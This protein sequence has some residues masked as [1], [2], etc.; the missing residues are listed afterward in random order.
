MSKI[1]IRP[2]LVAF[3]SGALV[4]IFEILG[5]R[6]VWPYIGTSLFVWTS[7]IALILWAL[8]VGHYVWGVLSDKRASYED[9]S[10]IFLTSAATILLLLT[11]KDVVLFFVSANISD[12]RVSAIILALLLFSPTSFLLGMLS[13]IV[14]KIR[15]TR[16]ETG[17][18]VVGRIGS[19]ATIGSIVGTLGAWFFL[20]PFFGV[21]LLLLALATT[22]VLL[23]LWVYNHWHRKYQIV[24]LWIIVIFYAFV[25]NYT[26]QAE[27]LGRYSY[28]TAY[29]HI[30]LS[31][32]NDTLKNKT[33]RDLRI[34]NI[35]HA[36]MYLEDNDLVYDYTRYYHLHDVLLPTSKNIVLFGGAAYSYPKSFLDTYPDK[37]L[38]V[39]EI[40]ND[41]TEIARK[42]FRLV[43]D[44]RLTIHHQDARVFLNTSEKKYDAILGDAFGSYFSVPY[45][46]TTR[47]VAQK[48][49]D[50][51]SENG[52]VILNVIGTLS[53]EKASF[54]EAEYKTY[55]EV[56]PEVFV[57]P[58]YSQE[59]D[60]IQNIMLVA[61]KN[62]A[63]LNFETDSREYTS[64]LSKRRYLD[65]PEDTQ[66]LT[67]DFAPV[68]Y[69]VG[70][71]LE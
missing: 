71:M 6:V 51:L 55:Q 58:V 38:D 9:I 8:S 45:Q 15:M 21:N 16:L 46:L 31:E 43:D 60:F 18:Q 53:W 2:E 22:C 14:T 49:Y 23:S 48:K 54:L 27:K 17:W 63:K 12:I 35:T 69:Y 13:P 70:K 26:V 52:I 40:D 24:L 67:D 28:D 19:I 3:S 44:P 42:H 47:E 61:A 59:D 29:S 57:I 10:K 66:V 64:F 56:F 25:I 41:I 33:V 68:D 30:S 62:A 7:L 34:D 39:V 5:S 11:L 37:M 4:M 50:M 65:I 36:G 1:D 32:R 20:I